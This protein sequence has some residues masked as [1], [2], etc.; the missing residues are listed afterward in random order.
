MHAR[1]LHSRLGRCAWH[2][3]GTYDAIF[4]NRHSNMWEYLG[5]PVTACKLATPGC[6]GPAYSAASELL[7]NALNAVL[8][9]IGTLG[10]KVLH[11]VSYTSLALKASRLLRGKPL[12]QLHFFLPKVL[13]KPPAA[14]RFKPSRRVDFATFLG[15]GPA[16]K[17]LRPGT[18]TGRL[19]RLRPR[20]SGHSPTTIPHL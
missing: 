20:G 5:A 4:G 14:A 7:P 13:L 10:S 1:F 6:E 9:S 18:R 15:P 2:K 17:W 8:G 19:Q 3:S 12:D 16:L 11:K